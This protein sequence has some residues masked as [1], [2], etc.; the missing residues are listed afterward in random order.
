MKGKKMMNIGAWPARWA[1]L[2]PEQTC[3][4]YEDLNLSN[5]I[6]NI[7]INKL[8][9]A[10]QESGVKKE[11]RVCILMANSHVFLEVFFALSKLGAILVPL[12]FRLST[13]ELEFIINNCEPCAMI[14]SPEFSSM[15]QELKGRIPSVTNFVCESRENP[16]QDM[17][18]ETQDYDSW[19][20]AFPETEPQP[21]SAVTLADTHIIMYTSGTTGKPKG[22]VISQGATQWSAVNLIHRY[23]MTPTD[24]TACCAPLF[25]IGALCVSATPS[26]YM[27]ARLVIQ[28]FFDPSG[29]I[30]LIEQN[31][32]TSMLGIP[33]MF[34]FMAQVPQFETADF[35][36]IR[37]FTTGGSPC[38]TSL[39]DTFLEK[40]LPIAM[41]YGLTEASIAS[42]L[43][44][45]E[46]LEKKG[47]CG[48]PLFHLDVKIVDQNGQRLPCGEAGEI[49][50]KGPIVMKCYWRRP[51]ESKAA[52]KDGWLASGDI[53]YLD[54]DGFLYIKDRSKDMYISGGE[55]VYPA[56][57]EDVI[58][59]LT[60]V[61]EAAVIGIP[62]DKW[63][64]TGLAVIV[65]RENTAVS[66]KQIINACLENLAKY[67]V[68]S[69]VIF[70]EAL[71]RT[72]SGKIMKN[73]LRETYSTQ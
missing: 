17:D 69:K 48:K 38:P 10:F 34:Q 39:L 1:D 2:Y 52:L 60:D 4:T 5:K 35:S 24:V 42:G 71:P 22:A 37:Y 41:G 44:P 65:A 31:R 19:I 49:M 15:V 27:G 12:N 16:G 40:G 57:V 6:F 18:Y 9:H 61:A 70:A 8:A 32:V 28:R 45:D 3:I 62:D 36:S 58:T 7:R 11:D 29:I 26:L 23:P 66:E 51:E 14:Y 67:K 33:V 55:N 68:P 50:I 30:S 53:G 46:A 63:G 13:N 56:E 72:T 64:E 59:A 21:E 54:S 43:A 47:S 25:H 20:S 73:S